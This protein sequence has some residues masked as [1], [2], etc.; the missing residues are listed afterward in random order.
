MKPAEA[1][2]CACSLQNNLSAI[3]QGPSLPKSGINVA[4]RRGKVF[5]VRN[6]GAQQP[7]VWRIAFTKCTVGQSEASDGED[8]TQSP[9]PGG[10]SPQDL[11]DAVDRLEAEEDEVERELNG[12]IMPNGSRD[13]DEV[14]FLRAS[15][16]T[17]DFE[18]HDI[19]LLR[20]L[21]CHLRR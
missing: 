16:R 8:G 7:L 6:F 4:F 1:M 2:A 19:N 17:S 21:I 11:V 14:S 10:G 18:M 13:L 15:R 20:Q 12:G 9:Q 3:P 5:C